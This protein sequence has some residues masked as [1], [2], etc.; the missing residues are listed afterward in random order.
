MDILEQV[1]AS[2]QEVLT[3]QAERIAEE[4]ALVKRQRKFTGPSLSQT[5]VFGWLDNPDASLDELT[6]MAADVGVQV[7]PQALE[8]R[9][10]QTTACF[11][12]GLLEASLEQMI[13][14]EPTA[15]EMLQRF[16]GVYLVD[17]STLVLPDELA[18][19]WQGCGGSSPVHTS[20]SLKLQ[21]RWD[22][23]RGALG[24]ELTHGRESDRNSIF[25]SETL[26]HGSLRLTDLGY[27]DL[28]QFEELGASDSYWL[29]R[30]Q[31]QCVLYSVEAGPEGE[32]RLHRYELVEF[33]RRQ[34]LDQVDVEV[35]LGA[36][37]QLPCRLI[38]CRV[39]A[40]VA[41]ERRRKLRAQSKKKGK[42]PS[43]RR[44]E[45]AN[46][47]L[48]ATN[49]DQ[50]LIPFKAAFVLARLRWQVELLFKLWKSH[51][52]IDDW[53]SRKPWR[54]LCEVYAKLIGVI[55]QHWLLLASGWRFGKKSL[56][57]AARTVGKHITSMACAFGRTGQARAERVREVLE[58][59]RNRVQSGCSMNSRNAEP[60]AYQL[61]LALEF[62]P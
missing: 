31:S 43:Q 18:E 29:S 30:V 16:E 36:E 26:P 9:F 49:A 17:G 44:L 7:S 32:E 34:T 58:T 4:T 10:N 8:Q 23:C 3:T 54:I 56:V 1:S 46:W 53:R 57:K 50:A 42:T 15:L 11:L 2:M 5:L 40:V 62:E 59:I 37:A 21:V 13:A 47:T 35:L 20:S 25:Q 55:I 38:A 33:L 27:F 28:K 52:K 24:M 22:L 61:L 51:G 48:L 41:N 6:Q 39:P 45:L 14:G 12:K 60:N 19:V